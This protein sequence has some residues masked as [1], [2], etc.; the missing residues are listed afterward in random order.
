M[1]FDAKEDYLSHCGRLV[2]IRDDWSISFE[3]DTDAG[4]AYCSILVVNLNV[5]FDLSTKRA[6]NIWGYH[7]HTGWIPQKLYIPQH[8]PGS[9]FLLGD[10]MLFQDINRI[11]DSL[12]WKTYYDSEIGWLCVG[13]Y[14]QHEGDIIVE[15]LT[16]TLAALNKKGELKALWLKPVFVVT[17]Q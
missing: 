13:D 14:I 11:E 16:D 8:F 7:P 3:A 2:Y 9:L 5:D 10:F 12:K 6:N 15:F 1:F 4:D 17:A